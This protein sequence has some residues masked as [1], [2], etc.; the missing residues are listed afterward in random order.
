MHA[1][2]IVFVGQSRQ[3]VVRLH[4][5]LLR[6]PLP[7]LEAPVAVPLVAL[8]ASCRCCGGGGSDPVVHLQR[9][10]VVLRRQGQGFIQ[11]SFIQT[12]EFLIRLYVSMC[13]MIHCRWFFVGT[14]YQ[15]SSNCC[16]VVFLFWFLNIF[17]HSNK[18]DSDSSSGK[19]CPQQ[20]K[21]EGTCCCSTSVLSLTVQCLVFPPS[22]RLSPQRTWTDTPTCP[23]TKKF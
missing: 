21:K 4:L 9:Q 7:L 16:Y 18:K 8:P 3:C 11:S 14:D 17:G 22:N 10:V 20:K 12:L 1:T 15:I 5:Q 6:L 23:C 19:H 2:H 13:S